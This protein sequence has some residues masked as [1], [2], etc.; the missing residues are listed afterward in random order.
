MAKKLVF[1]DEYE[2]VYPEAYFKVAQ[3]NLCKIDKTGMVLFYGYE[4][5]DKRGKRIIGQKQ[6]QITKDNFDT[7]FG[8]AELD[9]PNVNYIKQ[10]YKLADETLDVEDGENKK[11]FFDGALD[12]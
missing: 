5:K 10:A 11:S 9:K 4:N 6:Y 1:Q 7:Y 3:V 12:A 2:D 8:I